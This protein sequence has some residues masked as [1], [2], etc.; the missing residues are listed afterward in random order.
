MKC[1]LSAYELDDGSDDNIC[2]I[3]EDSAGDG[4]DNSSGYRNNSGDSE[5]NNTSDGGVDDLELS[6][7]LAGPQLV[8][9]ILTI[10]FDV[11]I[12]IFAL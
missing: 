10:F 3:P 12:A 1:C 9:F 8:I 11:R 7:S 5:S 2:E 6:S 4:P